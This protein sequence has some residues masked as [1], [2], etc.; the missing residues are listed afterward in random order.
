MSE[1]LEIEYSVR[2]SYEVHSSEQ[3]ALHQSSSTLN[4]NCRLK[5]P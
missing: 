1:H 5:P 4:P 3:A 2:R